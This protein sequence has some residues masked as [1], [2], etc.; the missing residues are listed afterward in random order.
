MNI[1]LPDDMLASVASAAEERGQDTNALVTE[2]VGETLKRWQVPGITFV[3]G[4]AGRRA[5]IE[6]TGI[7]VF[8]IV[9]AF[10]AEGRDRVQLAAAY[11][12]L[13][14]GQLD[15][16]LTYFRAFPEDVTPYL[17]IVDDRDTAHRLGE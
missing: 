6:G 8:E 17:D 7:D 12:W 13:D 11:H 14:D 15:A 5:R 2:M 9:Q 10:L 3:D 1:R 16:A 4:P